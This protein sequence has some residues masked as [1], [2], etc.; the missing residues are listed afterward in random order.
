VRCS[1]PILVLA[2]LTGACAAREPDRL[3]FGVSG[4]RVAG[5]T[6]AASDAALRRHLDWTL[7]QICTH[8]YENVKVDTIAAEETRQIVDEE[9]RCND[10]HLSLL[11]DLDLF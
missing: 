10:Y 11:P 5:A 6:D 1:L 4:D 8:G 3:V 7:S 9:V 2:L